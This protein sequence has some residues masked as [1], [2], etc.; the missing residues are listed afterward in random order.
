MIWEV[1]RQQQAGG[2]FV[3]CRDVHAPDVEMAKQ[4]AV[5]QHGRR[6]PTHALWVVSQADIRPVSAGENVEGAGGDGGSGERID[7]AGGDGESG[8]RIDGAG[9]DG[10]S[11]ER[12]DGADGDDVSGEWIVFRPN[13]MGYHTECGAVTARDGVDATRQ[14]LAAFAEDEETL[15]VVRREDIG[16]VTDDDAT[17]GGTTDKSYR[18]AQTY[19][20]DPV[21]E[22]VRSS[23][24]EQVEAERRNRGDV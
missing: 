15:W 6:K 18:F 21:A 12:I 11:G 9:G 1:F 20:V 24:R 3:Y 17:F 19:N 2:D 7:G 5:I 13:R 10:E 23:E 16:E 14:A 4:Y 22:E 8:E